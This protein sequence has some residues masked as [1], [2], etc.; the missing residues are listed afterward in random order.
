M[1]RPKYHRIPATFEIGQCFKPELAPL[2][3]QAKVL[4][5]ALFYYFLFGEKI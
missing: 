5:L 4:H 3:T 1:S 2:G